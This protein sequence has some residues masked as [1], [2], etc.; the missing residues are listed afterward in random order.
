MESIDP[1]LILDLGNRIVDMNNEALKTF[2]YAREQ[3]LGKTIDTVFP[4]HRQKAISELLQRCR[5]GELIQKVE[6]VLLN[7]SGKQFKSELTLGLLI[8]DQGDP[9]AVALRTSLSAEG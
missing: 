4:P 8:D 5:T 7:Q 6:E 2:G 3:L 9:D 1:I